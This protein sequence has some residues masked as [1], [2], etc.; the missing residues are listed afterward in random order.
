[1]LMFL[2]ETSPCGGSLGVV[3]RKPLTKAR[4]G[5]IPLPVELIEVLRRSE[6][7]LSGLTTAL[8]VGPWSGVKDINFLKSQGTLRSTAHTRC[9]WGEAS[10]TRAS[11]VGL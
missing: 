6:V 5:A 7:V 10:G 2:R 9:A 1:L 4:A 11:R 3:C 8:I